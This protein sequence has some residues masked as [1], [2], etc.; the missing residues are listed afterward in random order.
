MSRDI[1][2]CH[3]LYQYLPRLY[4]QLLSAAKKELQS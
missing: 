1:R 4:H 3:V 2:G